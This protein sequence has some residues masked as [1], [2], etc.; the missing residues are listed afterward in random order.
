ME[1]YAFLEMEDGS[2]TLGL[3]P[4]REQ[5]H[6][7][8]SGTAF[9]CNRF[10]LDDPCPWKVPTEVLRVARLPADFGSGKTP[11]V[12]WESPSP[13]PFERVF[14]SIQR[15]IAS[16]H[17]L[18]LV[19]VVT[20]KGVVEAGRARDLGQPAAEAASGLWSYAYSVGDAGFAGAT[21]ERF[22]RVEDNEVQTMA[23]AGTAVAGSEKR[24]EAD[25]KEIREHELVAGFLA[26][27]LARFGATARGERGLLE[28]GAITHFMTPLRLRL[29]GDFD[30]TSLIAA[31]HPTPAVGHL[32]HDATLL[33]RLHMIRA[34]LGCPAVFG[35]PFG[36]WDDGLFHSVVAIRG[37]FWK[38]QQ[39]LLPSG[40]GVIEQSRFEAEW[41]ELR[42]KREAVRTFFGI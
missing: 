36:L 7:P 24:F 31:L 42:L 13:D 27:R 18:K 14:A 3:G 11:S 22:I 21:P 5:A 32:P 17:A 9:Y 6:A 30:I 2:L 8:S 20:Q 4:F 28:L 19:P 15:E 1:D 12:A 41:E 34:E 35:A 16:G 38:G 10:G 29:E 33:S 39:V 40:C 23:L 37:L 25:P 26:E